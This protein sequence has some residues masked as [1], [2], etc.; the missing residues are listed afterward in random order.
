V[1]IQA[2]TCQVRRKEYRKAQ[3]DKA[4]EGRKQNRHRLKSAAKQ[5]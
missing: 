3:P 2:R 5:E 4:K 1:E